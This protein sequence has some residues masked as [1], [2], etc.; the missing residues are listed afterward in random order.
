MMDFWRVNM[1]STKPCLSWDLI[2]KAMEKNHKATQLLLNEISWSQ[3]IKD[4]NRQPQKKT[5][6]EL[7]FLT[8][9]RSI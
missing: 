8:L 2:T 1:N 6:C 3:P 5:V 4:L 9:V 7:S